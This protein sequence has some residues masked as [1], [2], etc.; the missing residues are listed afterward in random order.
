LDL[1]KVSATSNPKAVAG[2]LAGTVRSRGTAEVQAIGARAVNQA[3]KAIAIA[4]AF[5]AA[6]GLELTAVP[7]FVDLDLDGEPRTGIRFLVGSHSVSAASS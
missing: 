4:R 5:V 1:I 6:D 3:V 2:A 7:G